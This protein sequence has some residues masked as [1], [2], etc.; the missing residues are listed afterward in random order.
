MKCKTLYRGLACLLVFTLV[1][2]S[3]L[4]ASNANAVQAATPKRAS[5]HDPSIIKA[6]NTYYI[7]GSH[8]AD[9]KSTDMI[10]WSQINYDYSNPSADSVYGNVIQNFSESFQ[11]AGYNDGDCSGNRLAVW[12]PDVAWNPD[13]AW[14]DGSTGAYMLYYSASST[15]R[16][17]CI[18]YAVSRTVD[19]PYQYVDTIIYSGFTTHGRPD[20]ES[21]RNT[22]WDND[23][24]NIN[25]LIK[26]GTIE[27]ISDRW[28]FNNGDYNTN[29]VP[30]AIDPTILFDKKGEMHM[31]Y[32]SWSG[33]LF[34]LDLDKRTGAVRYPGKDGKDTVSGNTVDR[35]FGTHIA[36][37]NHQS[38]EGP[39]IIYDK[40]TDY[41]YLY[42][43]YGGLLT[44][45]GYNMRLFRSKNVTGPYLDAKGNNSN[46]SG[47][48]NER[49]GIKLIG[50]YRFKGQNTSY[51]SAGHNSA[52]I[53]D[54]GTHYLIYHQ[55][56]SNKWE[57]HEVRVRKQFM[58]EDGWP[59]TAVYE[60]H[61]EEIGHYDDADIPGTYDIIN[62]GTATN[63][64]VITA[65]TIQL[66]PDG[67]VTG[68]MSGTWSKKSGKDYD[69]ITITSGSVVYHGVFFLQYNE[70]SAPKQ[71]MTF[72]AIGNN[73]MSLWGMKPASSPSASTK[74]TATPVPTTA[75]TPVPTPI[76]TKDVTPPSS[77]D[78]DDNTSNSKPAVKLKKPTL[79]IKAGRK[80]ATL[81]WN[82][83]PK[84][85]GYQI[86]YSQKSSMKAA[87]K[88]K[89]P[90]QATKRVI[91]KLT[92]KKT[93]YFRIRA[94][95]NALYGPYSAK[96]KGKIR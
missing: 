62:H 11:W 60:N 18:G 64:S 54:D 76:P 90:K 84:A 56:F 20:G 58:N 48:S 28:F 75:A 43:T 81:T 12:A 21:T 5:V 1:T 9:A 13:Y 91:K 80:K 44:D 65:K 96:K 38:G 17:S 45:G 6:D 87:K 51:L 85:S 31:V 89:V 86:E 50:N 27:G 88:V 30:N 67:S 74:P 47:V 34:I 63:S 42:E 22:K 78:D 24:L 57:A 73:N 10:N 23:Y 15:W 94:Y 39:Y 71:T 66:L 25:K 69:Y 41:Y 55:R 95:R 16:R 70:D 92:S 29:N 37:G 59:V 26:N 72:T 40:E 2:S 46:Q 33:G 4:T 3:L 49:Y 83:I 53:D 61:G 79:K 36:G 7:F 52:L 82:K 14:E 19:G 77:N 32:G 35:Y 8:L 93:Y 68:D